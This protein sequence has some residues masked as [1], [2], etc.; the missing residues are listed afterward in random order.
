MR[1]GG[2]KKRKGEK[3]GKEEGERDSLS[4]LLKYEDTGTQRRMS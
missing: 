3:D 2:R 1:E 4:G